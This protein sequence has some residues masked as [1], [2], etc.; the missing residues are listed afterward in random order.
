MTLPVHVDPNI[1]IIVID[2]YLMTR[3]MVRTI[4]KGLGFQRI[5][6]AE[7]AHQALVKMEDQIFDLV[8]CDWNMPGMTGLEFLREVRAKPEYAT[9]PFIMLTAEAYRENVIAA[10]SAGVSEYIA[11][12]FTAQTLADK[13]SLVMKPKE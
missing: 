13:I 9:L 2:D 5:A 4:L 6:T 10:M 12:P 1:N 3:D 8:I 7:S 11:K